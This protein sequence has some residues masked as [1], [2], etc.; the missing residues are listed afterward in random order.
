MLFWNMIA[1][2][3]QS[4]TKRTNIICERN[5]D[6]LNVSASGTYNKYPEFIG[7]NLGHTE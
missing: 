2:Y 7:L 3:F 5:A 6:F 1:V 4:Y